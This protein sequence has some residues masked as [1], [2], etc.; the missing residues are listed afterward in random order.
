[1]SKG[2]LPVVVIL[3]STRERR[4]L[5]GLLLEGIASVSADRALL[6]GPDASD[7]VLVDL[8]T[9]LER[10]IRTLEGIRITHPDAN[11]VAL[12]DSKDPTLILRAMRAG[13]REFGVAEEGDEVC[14]IIKRLLERKAQDRAGG[15]I[16]SVFPAKGGVGATT[17]ATN[18]A[19]SLC[20]AGKRVVLV[21]IDRQLGNVLVFLDMA[22]RFSIADVIKNRSRLDTDLLLSSL[23][24]HESGL[25]VL[26]Q[27]DSLEDHDTVTGAEVGEVL[28]FLARHFDYVVCDGLRGFDELTLAVLDASDHVELLLTQDVVALKNAKKCLEIFAKLQYEAG[29]V[30]LVVNRFQKKPPIDLPFIVENLG[31]EVRAT[32]A[33]DHPAS[34]AAINRGR[35][36]SDVAAESHLTE[37]IARLAA[38]I[39]GLAW[40]PKQPKRRGLAALFGRSEAPPSPQASKPSTAPSPQE[41][42]KPNVTRR[43]PETS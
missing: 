43:T 16:V 38:G 26:A 25:Y 12:A 39:S 20:G 28:R 17:V 21:D 2:E 35:L 7:V 29:K 40:S 1:M 8:A 10:S 30:K 22:P 32:L 34:M 13:A 6:S 41:G 36:L 18:L 4:V 24:R 11:I 15:T 27:P 3:E 37:E 14:A 5:L 31:A 19:G 42:I 33:N 23:A 9:D